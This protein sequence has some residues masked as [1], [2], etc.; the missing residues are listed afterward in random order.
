[1]LFHSVSHIH[2]TSIFPIR[3]SS[4][5]TDWFFASGHLEATTMSPHQELIL[6]SVATIECSSDFLYLS[7]Q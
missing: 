4:L 1:M 2:N 5:V 3:E 6:S 7:N